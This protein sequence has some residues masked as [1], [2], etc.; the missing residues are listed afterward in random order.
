MHGVIASSQNKIKVQLNQLHESIKN[1]R[2]FYLLKY[3]LHDFSFSK[4]RKHTRKKRVNINMT[5][6]VFRLL[7]L[8]LWCTLVSIFF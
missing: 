5:K 1:E 3:N 8:D 4:L 7:Y 6:L 2:Y